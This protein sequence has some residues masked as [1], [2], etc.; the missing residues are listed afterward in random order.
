VA[1]SGGY[2]VSMAADRI[3][4]HPGTITG[5]IGVIGGKM[6]TSGLWR[7]IGIEWG[8]I[9]THENA[10]FWSSTENY[11]KQQWK[12]LQMWMDDTYR[13][14]IEKAARGR[15]LAPE[16]IRRAAK[17]RIWTG[18]EAKKLGLVDELGGF[19]V[20]IREAKAAAGL[21]E[22]CGIALKVFPPRSSFW[23]TLVPRRP[24]NSDQDP[25]VADNLFEWLK[26]W[27][28]AAEDLASLKRYGIMQMRKKTIE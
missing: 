26:P 27:R 13:D 17:G 10:G 15:N 25:A 5:S 23:E 18:E 21:P 19:A 3:I 8:E 22:D 24:E 28:G 2:F 4:A 7:K 11:S 12:R 6:V 16:E 14:F 20:A 9:F 1:A